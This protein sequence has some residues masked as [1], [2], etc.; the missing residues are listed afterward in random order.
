MLLEENGSQRMYRHFVDCKMHR[1]FTLAPLESEYK[2]KKK[3]Y[4]SCLS[5]FNKDQ[6]YTRRADSDVYHF[7]RL[8]NSVFHTSPY[9]K[10]HSTKESPSNPFPFFL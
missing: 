7:I 10:C 3:Q 5:Q 8:L 1:K 6:T 4:K 9:K 2:D